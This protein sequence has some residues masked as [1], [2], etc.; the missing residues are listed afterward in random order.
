M[1]RVEHIHIA[2]EA[3]KPMLP[4]REA[5]IIA[6]Q[7]ISGDRY[8]LKLGYYSH[9]PKPGRHITLIEAEVLKIFRSSSGYVL[10]RLTAD[11][12]LPHEVCGSILW[13]G[14]SYALVLSCSR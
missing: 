11:A 5:E 9:D 7:G 4:L 10:H 8:A 6:G 13:S 1:G 3:A 2:H 14:R 12:T